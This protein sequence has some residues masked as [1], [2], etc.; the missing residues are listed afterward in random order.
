[1][2]HRVAV[3]D[4]DDCQPRKCGLECV[5]YC[6]V[7]KT[8]SDC[9]ALEEDGDAKA[10]IDEDLCN[11][12]GICVKVCPFDAITVVNLAAEMAAEKV[13]Q[14]GPNS[15][16]LYRLP[17]PRKG[18]V[19]GLI[20]RNGTGKSTIVNIL[21]GSL[22]PN[23]GRYG[24][25][26]GPGWDEVVRRYA[27]TETGAHFEAVRDGRARASIKPQQVRGIASAFGGTGAELVER[28]DERGRGGEL[29]EELGLAGAA[30]GRRLGEMSGGELQRTAVAAAA[31]RDADYYFFD[32]PSSYNDAF[33]R[34]AV[35][36]VIRGLAAEGK[37]VMVVEHDMTLLDYLSDRVDVL[38]GE[39]AAYGIASGVMST[40]VGINAF[41]DG[42]LPAENVRFRDR[43]A[44]LGAT[45]SQAGG[46]G[47]QFGAA[48]EALSYGA[49]KKSY[50]GFS[51]EV[52]AGAVRKGEVVGVVGANSL[53]K[54][55]MM[56]ML[57][58]VEEP[59]PGSDPVR[60]AASISY[61]PQYLRGDSDATVAALLDG[62]AGAPVEGSLKE[63]QVVDHMG[64][65]RLYE[66][67]LSGLSGGELQKVAVCACLL[68]DAGAYALDEPSAFMDVEDR[69]A[70]ARFVQKFARSHGRAVVIIDHDVQLVDLVSDSMVVF[71]GEPGK[72][73]RASPPMPKSGAMNAFLGSLGMTFRRDERSGRPRVNKAGSRLDKE[74]KRAGRYYYRD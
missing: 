28:Y 20:G 23:L 3:L 2:T 48:D 29:M 41:L 15:F 21:S 47:D 45:S 66:R 34:A 36:R 14:Y 39:P 35:A 19:V 72:S 37:S 17:S 57:A 43:R 32:E 67:P 61:K 5:K 38:Y 40:K 55:T 26:E 12:C 50:Q 62:A 33:Q 13:H 53:G 25:G 73:G 16:R 4:K 70:L 11:G 6:P 9:I 58:G 51:L 46:G 27:G 65:K 44:A 10:R 74:Q 18:E 31:A 60:K 30:A 63:E 68:R 8:G 22:R 42:Y 64:V 69:I 7:N 49:L 1:M 24:E 59:G 56:K 54:T 52:G 71:G